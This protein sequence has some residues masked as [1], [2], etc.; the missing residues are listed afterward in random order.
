MSDKLLSEILW[1][2]IDGYQSRWG[3]FPV[4]SKAGYFK[5]N[6]ELENANHS[7]VFYKSHKSDRWWMEVP[8]PPQKGSKYERHHLVPCNKEDY[9][10]AMQ[11]EIPDL[12]WKTY[13]KLT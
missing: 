13:Q 5:F 3:D 4:S 6:V 11:N 1:Y 7:I 10:H 8:Y 12:W 2:F 9:D